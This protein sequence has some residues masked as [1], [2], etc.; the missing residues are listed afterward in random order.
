[1]EFFFKRR[2]GVD[3]LL[4]RVIFFC[5]DGGKGEGGALECH[6][7][8]SLQRMPCEECYRISIICLLKISVWTGENDFK[9]LLA[10]AYFFFIKNGEK[11]SSFSK[12]S[13][14]YGQDPK[15]E[16]LDSILQA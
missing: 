11:E 13:G 4:H 10:D 7:S 15:H 14:T 9:T 2:P 16:M 6:A 3:R 8:Y 1:M 12:I 5:V